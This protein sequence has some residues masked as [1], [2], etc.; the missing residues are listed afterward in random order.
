MKRYRVTHETHYEYGQ[1]VEIGLHTARISPATTASQ[2]LVSHE[3]DV[4]PLPAWSVAF[5]DHYGNSMHHFSV[6]SEHTTLT[7]TQRAIVD[8]MPPSQSPTRASPTWETVRDSLLVDGIAAQPHVV[9]FIYP[10]PLVPREPTATAFAQATFAAGT[11]ILVGALELARRFKAVF[12]YAPGS[13]NVT[14]PV[15]EVMARKTGVCQDFAHAMIA[16]LRGIGL[17]ARYVSGYLRTLKRSEAFDRERGLTG[18][19]ESHAW[20]SVWCGAEV[21]WM[22]FDPTNALAVTDEHIVVAYGRDYSD[23]TPLRGVIRGGGQHK[24]NVAVAVELVDADLLDRAG[25]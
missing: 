19:D 17:P 18:A 1:P 21:G 4:S 24:L 22:E 15:S 10:S 11:N 12:K 14:T 5:A 23:V 8:V 16:G 7:V 13:T 3:I 6:E 20:V 2:K 25:S 9:E